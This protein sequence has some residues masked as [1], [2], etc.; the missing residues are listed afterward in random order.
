M[1][2]PSARAS[3]PGSTARMVRYID[4]TLSWK[5]T[6]SSSGVQSSTVPA[7]TK[8]AQLT[9][10]STRP[11]SLVRAPTASSLSTSS[12]RVFSPS[13]PASAASF[14]SVAQ[15]SAPARPS[16]SAM[17]RPMPL[18]A[19]VTSATRPCKPATRSLPDVFPTAA[20]RRP[21]QKVAANSSST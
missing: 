18:P 6:S 11:I 20:A 12:L 8:P 1:I 10:M 9:R 17:A 14:T 4:F 19:A 5:A 7:W 16:P 3:M 21:L 2:E 15:T 13:S